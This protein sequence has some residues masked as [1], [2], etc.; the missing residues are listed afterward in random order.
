MKK[1]NQQKIV[2]VTLAARA[3]MPFHAIASEAPS[4]AKIRRFINISATYFDLPP[5]GDPAWGNSTIESRFL[6]SFLPKVEELEM[7]K[8]MPPIHA[9]PTIIVNQRIT[10][11]EAWN[12]RIS[13]SFGAIIP[14]S[15]KLIGVKSSPR[16]WLM[17]LGL[18]SEWS[19]A[20]V[21]LYA[22]AQAQYVRTR[23]T[24]IE[25]PFPS[26]IETQSEV[27]FASL[28]ARSRKIPFWGSFSI[29]KKKT[30]IDIS[31]QNQTLLDTTDTLQDAPFPAI[32]E[33]AMGWYQKDWGVHA[34]IGEVFIPER[35]YMP[36]IFVGILH[37]FER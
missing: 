28:G 24:G 25:K 13:S 22:S 35:L 6:F 30:F 3:A 18:A 20:N 10:G 37:E 33:G 12:L 21:D 29:G 19:L 36:R 4:E 14:G 5:F 15:E 16:Q 1:G 32:L 34:G 23:I 2:I 11:N 7:S 27:G 26:N 8:D 17:N 31:A 9:I